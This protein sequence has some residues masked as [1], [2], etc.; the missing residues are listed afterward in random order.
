MFFLQLDFLQPVASNNEASNNCEQARSFEGESAIQP[1]EGH[2][3]T[4]SRTEALWGCD[5][6]G[7]VKRNGANRK[8]WVWTFSASVSVTVEKN[9]AIGTN[10]WLKDCN[11]KCIQDTKLNLIPPHITVK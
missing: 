1:F 7:H 11:F 10:A 2:H 4:A 9:S 5:R 8:W 3:H 6:E